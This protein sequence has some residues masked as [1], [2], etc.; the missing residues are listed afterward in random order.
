M[1]LSK[2]AAR[3]ARKMTTIMRRNGSWVLFGFA[4]VGCSQDRPAN[5]VTRPP[6]SDEIPPMVTVQ[7]GAVESGL[8]LGRLRESHELSP[9]AITR[10]P[11]T[12]EQYRS[13]QNAGACPEPNSTTCV[14]RHGAHQTE[15]GEASER[16]GGLPATCFG[17]EQAIAYCAWIGGR[18]PIA[19]E[20]LLAARGVGVRRYAWGN[21]EPTCDQH[22]GATIRRGFLTQSCPRRDASEGQIVGEYPAGSSPFLVEDVLLT[23]GELIAPSP[24]ALA[25][26]CQPPFNGCVVT[27]LK[28]GAIDSFAPIGSPAAPA[29][30][31]WLI[32]YSFRCVV[33]PEKG[34]Q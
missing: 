2:Q 21:E 14:T 13:C 33:V 25:S 4:I 28:P 16:N 12:V 27:G 7:G 11:V 10:Y 5:P 24:D 29:G 6:S 31:M 18:L 15:N 23:P 1:K 3:K 8:A 22:P 30:D 26:A 20:W 17:V 19:S 32:P 34:S 9:F